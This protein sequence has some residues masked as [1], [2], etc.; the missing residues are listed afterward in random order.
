MNWRVKAVLEGI[1]E[2]FKTGDV[3]KAVAYSQ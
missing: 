3:P 2:R 1:L